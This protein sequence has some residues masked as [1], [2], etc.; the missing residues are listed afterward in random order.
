MVI[1][2]FVVFA[3]FEDKGV[4]SPID[5]PDRTILLGDI[6]ALVQIV[7]TPEQVSRL[8]EADPSLRILT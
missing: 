6:R 2:A 7:R 3:S 1:L 8:L 5:P 4:E